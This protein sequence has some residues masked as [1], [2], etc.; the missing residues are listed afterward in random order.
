MFKVNLA[1]NQSQPTKTQG[2]TGKSPSPKP[3]ITPQSIELALTSARRTPQNL[4]SAASPM[5]PDLGA[6][7]LH[8][9][10]L[11]SFVSGHVKVLRHDAAAAPLDIVLPDD[12][13]RSTPAIVGAISPW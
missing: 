2:S 5:S 3:P 11:P 12:R 4:L 10:N 6:L 8:S 7:W 9:A 13:G 1:T